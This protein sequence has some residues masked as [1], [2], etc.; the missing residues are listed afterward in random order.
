MMLINLQEAT[1]EY[2]QKL[3]NLE[4]A[5]QEGKI[6]IKEVDAEVASLMAEMS[7]KRRLAINDF[8]QILQMWLTQQRETLIRLGVLGIISSLWFFSNN[9]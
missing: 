4:S 8:L 5:Y 1:Q 9:L 2:W 7:R 6:S 3:D